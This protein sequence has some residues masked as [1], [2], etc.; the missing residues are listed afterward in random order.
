MI[1]VVSVS[2]LCQ[3]TKKRKAICWTAKKVVCEKGSN[4]ECYWQEAYAD[5]SN[6]WKPTDKKNIL[7]LYVLPSLVVVSSLI[8]KKLWVS[9]IFIWSASCPVVSRILL[10]F[11]S[12]MIIQTGEIQ[13]LQH[14]PSERN[15]HYMHESGWCLTRMLLFTF[16]HTSKSLFMR[17]NSPNELRSERLTVRQTNPQIYVVV[18]GCCS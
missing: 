13:Q 7:F 16:S 11:F 15:L 8:S 10:L 1:R 4:Y 14:Q 18:N 6:I 12:V 9:L 5:Y 17:R 3:C 2:L